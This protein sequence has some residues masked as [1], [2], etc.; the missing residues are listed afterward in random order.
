MATTLFKCGQCGRMAEASEM[1]IL[2]EEDYGAYGDP[3][4]LAKPV[5][6]RHVHQCGFMAIRCKAHPN[7]EQLAHR[8]MLRHLTHGGRVKII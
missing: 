5:L 2:S 8:A 3:D 7:A 6:E 1:V 4:E